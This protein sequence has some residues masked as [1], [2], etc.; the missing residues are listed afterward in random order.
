LFTDVDY[1][2]IYERIIIRG[3]LDRNKRL[4]VFVDEAQLHPEVSKI[5]KYLHD[6]YDIKFFLTGSASYY[7]KNLF[8]ESLAGRKVIIELYPLSFSEFLLFRGENK[9]I[10]K[11]LQ[12][13]TTLHIAEYERYDTLYNEYVRWGG[14][15]EVVLAEGERKKEELAKDIFSSYYQREVLQ[16][17][18]WRKQDIFR[19][20]MILLATRTGSLLDVAKLSQELGINRIT[21]QNYL[22][23]L[24][25]T[26]FVSF[27]GK[28]SKS[29]DRTISGAKKVYFCDN[30][31]MRVIS[32]TGLGAQLENTVYHQLAHFGAESVRYYR[33]VNG[34]E[35]D[36][37]VDGKIGYEVKTTATP[38]DISETQNLAK[39][40]GLTKAIVISRIFVERQDGVRFAQFL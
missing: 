40:L 8:P 14:F 24:E 7:L 18:E 31:I 34:K 29:Q 10:Y 3:G 20:L 35:L 2:D 22:A 33:T 19:D 23:F 21:V 13:K 11:E 32:E 5:A 26:Y 12:A 30:G 25:A 27:I 17:G 9:L 15:P 4:N 39:K 36:F 1:N 37:V 38:S 28:H 6:H 16:L